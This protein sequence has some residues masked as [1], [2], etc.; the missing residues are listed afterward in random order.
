MFDDSVVFDSENITIRRNAF[1]FNVWKQPQKG[2]QKTDRKTSLPEFILNN[3][4]FPRNGL[5][6]RRFH[7]NFLKDFR[8]RRAAAL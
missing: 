1:L 8:K 4:N 7:E 6:H 3:L 5:Y 2:V